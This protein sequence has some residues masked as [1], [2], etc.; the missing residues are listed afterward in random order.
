MQSALIFARWKVGY[1]ILDAISVDYLGVYRADGYLLHTQTPEALSGKTTVGSKPHTDLLIYEHMRLPF[2]IIFLLLIGAPNLR[3]A[4]QDETQANTPLNIFLD[5]GYCDRLFLQSE[6]NYVNHVRDQTLADVHILITRLRSAANGYQHSLRFIG[7]RQFDAQ[8][9]ELTLDEAPNTTS[10]DRNK[11]IRDL[12]NKGLV[13]YWIQTPFRDRMNLTVESNGDLPETIENGDDDPWN[14]WVFSIEGGGSFEAE[15]NTNEYIGWARIRAD[16]V[17]EDWRVRNLFYGR[18]DSR[19]F[20]KDEDVITSTRERSYVSSSAVRSITEHW[21]AGMFVSLFRSNFNNYDLSTRF[22]PAI[23]FSIFPYSEVV[24]HELTVSYRVSH[25]YRDYT[26]QTIFLKFSEHLFNHSVVMAARFRQPWG[27]LFAELE[28]SHFFH[29]PSQNRL[30]FE[31][32]LSLRVSKGL[33]ITIGNEFEI[34]NDQRS[35]P[36]RDISLEELLLAQRQS[37]TNFRVNGQ[38]GLRYTFGSL[39]NNV[40]NT[41]L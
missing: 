12:L 18:Y 28:G 30:E 4:A 39:Y 23:E 21:S 19:R 27:S 24:D 31:G 35:L 16:H 34:I 11:K 41:R 25:L 22:A 17:S 40:V 6:L 37:A 20:E 8:E 26:E 7:Q 3:I 2:F 15:T 14:H 36:A 13:A 9:F 33:S 10:R 29:D 5:C 32:H 38:V 1:L